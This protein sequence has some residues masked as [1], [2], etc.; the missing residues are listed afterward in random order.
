MAAHDCVGPVALALDSHLAMHVPNLVIQEVVR[1]FYFGWY[2]DLVTTLPQL[3]QGYL[4]PLT[5]PGLGLRLQPD[6]L[7]RSDCERR[8]SR[9]EPPR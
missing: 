6:V 2:Q 3:K 1:A 9:G 8:L 4:Y 5:E 7:T